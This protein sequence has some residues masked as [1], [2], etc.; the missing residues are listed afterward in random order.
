MIATQLLV[1]LSQ[2]SLIEQVQSLPVDGVGLLRSE[3]M[4]LN[5][6][7][8]QHPHSWLLDGRQAELLEQWSEQIMQFARAFAPRPVFYRSLD[9]RSQDLPSLSDTSQSS[10]QSMLGERGTFSYL[11]NPAVFEL[12]LTSFSNCTKSWLQQHSTLLLPFVRIVEEFS[13]VV[14]KLSKQG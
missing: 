3:L 13:F 2:S 9:W 7:N 14:T 11:Q 4:V 12:E 5:I 8:G 1:N 6:L 10:P